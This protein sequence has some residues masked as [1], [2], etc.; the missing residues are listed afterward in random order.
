M[1]NFK[2]SDYTILMVDD[3]PRN[4]QVL[5]GTLRELE[6]EVE[7]A[8]NGRKALEWIEKIQRVTELKNLGSASPVDPT[9]SGA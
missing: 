8:T 6:Y 5:G 7:Y 1:N 9:L 2:P 3:S 4:L